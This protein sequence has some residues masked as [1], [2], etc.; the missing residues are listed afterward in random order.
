MPVVRAI[1]PEASL[2]QRPT[3]DPNTSTYEASNR[4]LEKEQIH[5]MGP[6]DSASWLHKTAIATAVVVL[7]SLPVIGCGHSSNNDSDQHQS[8]SNNRAQITSYE[9]GISR[10]NQISRDPA[11]SDAVKKKL[12]DGVITF[13]EYES[14]VLSMLSCV[15]DTGASIR[16]RDPVLSSR[17][18]YT[19]GISWQISKGDLS[20]EVFACEQRELGIIDLL[21]KEHVAPSEQD[22]QHAMKEMASCLSSSGLGE[23]VPPNSPQPRDFQTIPRTLAAA[24]RDQDIPWYVTCARQ[25]QDTFGLIGFIGESA[26]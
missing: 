12:A 26:D 21:W 24:G 8:D 25:V 19:W 14:A 17:G 1:R 6:P 3:T 11:T 5:P 23:L 18:L 4:H 2:G 15:K 16:Q 7:C 22:V 9:F 20:D 13:T 10:A